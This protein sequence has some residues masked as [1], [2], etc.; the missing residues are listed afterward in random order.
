MWCV[1]TGV[2]HRAERTGVAPAEHGAGG[3]TGGD[4]A[5]RCRGST[6]RL[7][8]FPGT[9][10]SPGPYAPTASTGLGTDGRRETPDGEQSWTATAAT[11]AAV[12]GS[13]RRLPP[14]HP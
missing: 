6:W 8:R 1:A 9:H 5:A 12:R 10:A 11:R 14:P 4:G 7:H 13:P 3:S 2:S